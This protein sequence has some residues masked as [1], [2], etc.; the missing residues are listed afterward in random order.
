M[1]DIESRVADCLRSDGDQ[2]IKVD[3][4]HD[5]AI[6]RAGSIRR[7]R[8]ALGAVAGGG[9]AAVVAA[10]FVVAPW[11]TSGAGDSSRLTVAT[12]GAKPPAPTAKLPTTLPGATDSAP[13]AKR[14]ASVGTDPGV[15]HFDVDLQALRAD[16]SD[17]TSAAGYERLA[18]PDQSGAPRVEILIGTDAGALD[19]AKKSPSLVEFRDGEKAPLHDDG[20]RVLTTV[21]GRQGTLQKVTAK[22]TPASKEKGR[23]SWVLRWQPVDGL[24]A[25]VQVFDADQSRAVLAAKAMRL[26]RAQR[27]ATPLQLAPLPAGA[28]QTECR[29]VIRRVPLPARGVWVLSSIAIQQAGGSRVSLW[30]EDARRGR[31]PQDV[32]AFVSNRTVG[33]FPAQWRREDPAGLWVLNFGPAAELF[34]TAPTEADATQLVGGLKVAP[35]L[36][37]PATWPQPTGG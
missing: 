19:A 20:A 29:T 36:A 24:H 37:R 33:G 5:A 3:G 21:D 30:A 34:V 10:G 12:G 7:R 14:P 1:I 26:D 23:F 18:I 17:W 11:S 13:A 4:L 28:R 15:L 32:A 16:V 6:S 8:R 9:L 27:C 35:D 22:Y 31:N 2:A 25:L